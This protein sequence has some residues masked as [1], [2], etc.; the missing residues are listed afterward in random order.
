M[1]KIPMLAAMALLLMVGCTK[2]SLIDSEQDSVLNESGLTALKGQQGSKPVNGNANIQLLF[3]SN[4]TG[5]ADFFPGCLA[6]GRNLL[7]LGNFSGKLSGYGKINATL[8]TYAFEYCEVLPAVPPNYIEGEP[9]V[10]TLEARGTL[11]LGPNDYCSITFSGTIYPWYYTELG[12]D[13]GTFIGTAETFAGQGKLKGL[14]N[15]TYFV[16]GSNSFGPSVNLETG[17]IMLRFEEE[18]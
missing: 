5:T 14:E 15:K 10:Y 17:A 7:R 3:T 12:I 8:S 11:A 16:T 9:Y 1:K 13:G 4:S 2:D 18:R 6:E